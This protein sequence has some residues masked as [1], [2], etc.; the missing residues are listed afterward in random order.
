MSDCSPN[1]SDSDSA[2]L[3]GVQ[4]ALYAVLLR[5]Y[6]LGGGRYPGAGVTV[7][8][9]QGEFEGRHLDAALVV[10]EHA[11][12]VRRRGDVLVL[13][14]E[15]WRTLTETWP[16]CGECGAIEGECSCGEEGTR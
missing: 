9:L 10:L 16:R 13:S 14:E 2:T 1:E 3:A 11:G 6:H 12:H 5:L 8:T 15:G 7:G 4:V